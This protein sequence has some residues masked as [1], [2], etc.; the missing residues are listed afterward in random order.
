MFRTHRE[1]QCRDGRAAFHVDHTQHT[2]EMTFSCSYEKQPGTQSHR[3]LS[4]EGAARWRSHGVVDSPA[5]K[6]VWGN[7]E[8]P[9]QSPT[10]EGG[11]DHDR[12]KSVSK[13]TQLLMRP[14]SERL[15]QINPVLGRTSW[16]KIMWPNGSCVTC[17][18]FLLCRTFVP[19]AVECF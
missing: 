8:T 7:T 4:P 19:Q 13:K 2:W 15:L 3:Q 9:V 10:A 16:A 5:E 11:V 18:V 14:Q 12:R 6:E 17:S 1:D